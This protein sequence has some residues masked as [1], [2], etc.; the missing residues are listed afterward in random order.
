MAKC[1]TKQCK[2]CGGEFEKSQFAKA[3]TTSAGTPTYTGW[4]KKCFVE[5][6]S[7]IHIDRVKQ[8][9][10]ELNVELKCSSCGYDRCLSALDF[11]H[12]N[13]STKEKGIGSMRGASYDS[14]VAEMKK[15]IM[16]C[17][18]CHVELHA[19]IA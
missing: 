4:C 9:A 16:L 11:H 15:C 18:N 14:I 10:V 3:G 17:K 2:G 19:V 13:P 5:R 8:A 7:L 12:I 1:D 6:R